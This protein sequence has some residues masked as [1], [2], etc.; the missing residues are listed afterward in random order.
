M[1]VAVRLVNFN[2]Q[3]ETSTVEPVIVNNFDL[4]SQEQIDYL[5]SLI[6]T[7]YEGDS[8]QIV[9]SCQCNR[10]KGEH[11]VNVR[12]EICGT[13]VMAVTERP[14]ESVL[15]IKPPRGVDTLINP[16]AWFIL[17][18][19]TTHNGVRL[20]E[21]LCN[22]TMQMPPNPPKAARKLQSLA[23]ERGLNFFFQNFD[24]IMAAFFEHGLVTGT[25]D[26][27][28]DLLNFIRTYRDAI[29]AQALP[30][31]SKMTFIT[32]KTVNRT[33]ADPT[34]MPA[35]DAVHTIASTENSPTPLSPKQLQARAVKA[36]DLLSTFHQNFIGEQ[37]GKKHGW[38]RKHVYG[39]RLHF[40]FRAV[41]SSLSE[42]HRY[43]E[44]HLPWSVAVMVYQIHLTSMLMKMP[45]WTPRTILTFLREHVLQYHPLIDELFKKMIAESPHGGLPILFNRNPTLMRGSIQALTVT[46]VKTDVSINSVSMSVLCLV[47][48]NADFDGDAL[49]GMVI[50]DEKMYQQF[51]RLAPHHGVM[52]LTRP[53]KISR[54]IKLPPQ[55]VSTIGAYV[56]RATRK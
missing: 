12:C 27:K 26:Q 54:N 7:H 1:G 9:P 41:I 4:S 22:P 13:Y 18:K 50:L 24:E 16:E 48:P 15:W 40:T 38:F 11:N 14:L 19:Q 33:Y 56:Q 28:D 37:L 30:I 52:D 44:I 46:E 2:H 42:N 53:Y 39:S 31:P 36:I 45:G 3:F 10:T 29:F 21:W 8:L 43:D 5:N 55:V 25:R 49:N 34:M 35:I 51:Q 32:E 23:I 17:N 20:L 47:A 6:Y